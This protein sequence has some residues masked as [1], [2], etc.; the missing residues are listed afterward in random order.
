MSIFGGLVSCF[1]EPV[2][3]LMLNLQCLV[4]PGWL[5]ESYALL[6]PE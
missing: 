5:V 6:V 2:A 4:G 1:V 3:R